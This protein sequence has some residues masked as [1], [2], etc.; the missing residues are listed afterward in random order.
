[1]VDGNRDSVCGIPKCYNG[2]AQLV[3]LKQP[4]QRHEEAGTRVAYLSTPQSQ[5][6]LIDHYPWC[7]PLHTTLTL[8]ESI[9]FRLEGQ[10]TERYPEGGAEDG[11]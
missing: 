3:Q 11:I 10:N 1:M 5:E 6:L 2:S 8:R 9:V 7:L 4:P